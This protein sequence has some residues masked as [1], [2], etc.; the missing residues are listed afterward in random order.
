MDFTD[1]I[2][3]FLYCII[4]Y[5]VF[6][7]LKKL[8]EKCG[9]FFTLIRL[10]KLRHY[11]IVYLLCITEHAV[12]VIKNDPVNR[13]VHKGKTQRAQHFVGKN[14]I[15]GPGYVVTHTTQK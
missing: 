9:L 15:A 4:M 10:L 1:S 13:K 2:D 11:E 3:F 8:F 14:S 7:H 6:Y 5:Y 12:Y